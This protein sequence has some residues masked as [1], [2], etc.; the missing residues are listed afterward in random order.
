METKIEIRRFKWQDLDKLVQCYCFGQIWSDFP[1]DEDRKCPD[2]PEGQNNFGSSFSESVCPIC[3]TNLEPFWKPEEVRQEIRTQLRIPSAIGYLAFNGPQIVGFTWGYPVDLVF[4]G[5]SYFIPKL[6]LRIPLTSTLVT[7]IFKSTGFSL[8]TPVFYIDEVGIHFDFRKNGIATQ[9]TTKLLKAIQQA[10]F[11]FVFL[12][13]DK[14]AEKAIHLYE[15]K[16]EFRKDQRLN[17]PVY[18]HR[19]YW[20]KKLTRIPPHFEWER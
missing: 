15:Q 1:W 12:R 4:Q 13:T 14:R 8:R 11:E 18:P 5:F 17:D 7:K 6:K 2:C 19:A 10:Q 20:Y 16:L 9:L 3:G